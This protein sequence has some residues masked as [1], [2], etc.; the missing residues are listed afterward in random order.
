MTEAQMDF[1]GEL[2]LNVN[3]AAVWT[4]TKEFCRIVDKRLIGTDVKWNPTLVSH[5][6][7]KKT[8]KAIEN[9]LLWSLNITGLVAARDRLHGSYRAVGVR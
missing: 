5:Y 9:G 7:A 4:S 2:S 6:W 8:V 3:R 1:L